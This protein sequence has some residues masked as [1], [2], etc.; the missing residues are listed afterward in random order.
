[1]KYDITGR[2]LDVT[3][4]LRAHVE[5]HLKKIEPV[6]EGKPA[7]THIV[8]EVERG[9]SKSE[10][11]VN[12]RNDVLTAETVDGDMYNSISLTLDKIEKQARKLKDKII[13]KSHKAVKVSTL[14]PDE[15]PAA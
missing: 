14:A 15:E 8:I 9:R 5:S 11:I 10:I 13:D 4:A 7:K 2:H 6:F 3:D 12:W 1:M